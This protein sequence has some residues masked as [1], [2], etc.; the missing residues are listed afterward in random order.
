MSPT[1]SDWMPPRDRRDCSRANL[2]GRSASHPPGQV[3]QPHP[4]LDAR[5]VV[6]VIV[7]PEPEPELILDFEVDVL[8]S[9]P[10]PQIQTL[11]EAGFRD[12]KPRP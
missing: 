11:L 6:E 4:H 2:T 7:I 1:A 8:I 5:R 12:L 10:T 9:D 3:V